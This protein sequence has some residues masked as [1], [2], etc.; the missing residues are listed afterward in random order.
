MAGRLAGR[1]SLAGSSAG[2]TGAEWRSARRPGVGQGNTKLCITATRLAKR[3]S[4]R[5]RRTTPPKP[6]RRPDGSPSRRPAGHVR[7][8]SGSPNP[9]AAPF[10][11][12]NPRCR[13]A[14]T[15]RCAKAGWPRGT[16]KLR[17]APTS[18]RGCATIRPGTRN[19]TPRASGARS[20][21]HG[22]APASESWRD[23][24]PAAADAPAERVGFEPTRRLPAYTI[25]SRA[26]SATPAPLPK[27]PRRRGTLPRTAARNGKPNRLPASCVATDRPVPAAE[28]V[29]FEPTRLITYRFSRAAPSTTRTPLQAASG[30]NRSML[31]ATGQQ[32]RSASPR[33]RPRLSAAKPR[34]LERAEARATSS[35]PAHARSTHG[36]PAEGEGRDRDRRGPR[37]RPRRGAAAGRR[38]RRGGRQRPRRQYRG[39]GRLAVAGR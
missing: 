26:C 3:V 5:C 27:R 7:K 36:R 35:Q 6:G 24:G 8:P 11:R 13:S 39:R 25:S 17:S 28:R 38:G 4:D 18:N 14:G 2:G 22:T 1:S 23:S 21:G 10:V 9:V 31:R 19:S 15:T 32:Q 34:S 16:R 20:V 30:R 12:A 37:H 33:L 29:G